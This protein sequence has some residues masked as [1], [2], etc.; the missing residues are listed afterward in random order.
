MKKVNKILFLLLF[1]CIFFATSCSNGKTYVNEVITQT[2][3]YKENIT[4][5]DVEDALVLATEKA[6]PTV[7][8]VESTSRITKGF[9]SGVIVKKQE[10]VNGYKYYVV[11]NF[12]V[13]STNNKVNSYINVYLGD[14]KE[15]IVASCEKYDKNKDIAILSFVS[16]RLLSVAT[17]GDSTTLKKSRFVI[18]IGNPYDLS[19]YYNSSSVG[20]ISY[21]NRECLDDN[22]QTNFY[23]QHTAP[24]NSGNSGG[25]LFDIHG[26]LIG[27]N[28]W[29][30]ATEEIEGMG[31]AIPLHI[32]KQ[33]YPEYFK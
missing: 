21:P 25:G 7:I 4:I 10:I 22:G 24:I 28:T 13:I 14:Y 29:K 5:Y 27:I 2:V 3:E 6:S 17:L 15:T 18:A 23:I 32:I 1:M 19:V 33:D 11:T 16:P 9:G 8:G 31:F 20:Y 30:Y 26:N 12:H